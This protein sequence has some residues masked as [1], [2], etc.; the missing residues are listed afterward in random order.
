[1]LTDLFSPADLAE[2]PKLVCKRGDKIIRQGAATDG[3]YL[4]VSGR[5]RLRGAGKTRHG[6]QG[7][8]AL[9][10]VDFLAL[11]GYRNDVVAAESCQLLCLTR[12][13][14]RQ[15][16]TDQNRLLWPLSR[17]LAGDLV[18]RDAAV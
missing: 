16:I 2:A 5:A 12:D 10:M 1:M 3:L 9:A 14:F 6:W 11:T 15:L 18:K 4:L 8:E 17:G 13:H 7:G